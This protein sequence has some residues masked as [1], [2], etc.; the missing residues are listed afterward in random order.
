MLYFPYIYISR[1]IFLNY[2]II[3]SFLS[4]YIFICVTPP[5]FIEVHVPNK[6]NERFSCVKECRF[7]HFL[8]CFLLNF[9]N[10]QRVRYLLFFHFIEISYATYIYLRIRVTASIYSSIDWTIVEKTC[11]SS[12]CRYNVVMTMPFYLKH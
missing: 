5:L 4:F 11:N 7:C 8:P 3:H 2:S 9:G 10:V 1:Y 12:K 6:E